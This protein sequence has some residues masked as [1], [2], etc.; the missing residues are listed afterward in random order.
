MKE[1]LLSIIKHYGLRP[2]LKH[3]QSEVWEL[4]E[5]IIN[6]EYLPFQNKLDI[7]AIA[8]EIADCCV[9]LGQFKNYYEITDEEL[10]KFF[11]TN[12]TLKEIMV[13]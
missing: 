10:E 9:M 7:D 1:D 3:F 11:V 4:N 6:A 8:E 2:Q 13:V 5:A 12:H